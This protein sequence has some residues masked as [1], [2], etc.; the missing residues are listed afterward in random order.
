MVLVVPTEETSAKKVGVLERAEAGW[1][2]GPVF[3]VRKWASEYGLSLEQC[4]RLWVLVTP[5]SA[6]KKAT[7][8][9][10]MEVPRSASSPLRSGSRCR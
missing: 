3:E 6:S 9:E 7:G 1:E 2:T 8:L 10:A 4:G 5:R